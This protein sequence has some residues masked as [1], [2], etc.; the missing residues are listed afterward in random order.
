[1]KKSR[2]AGLFVLVGAGLTVNCSSG[3]SGESVSSLQAADS[4]GPEAD[5]AGDHDRDDRDRDHDHHEDASCSISKEG[6]SAYNLA[7]TETHKVD[8]GRL[9]ITRTFKV[10]E[11]TGDW[12]ATS[13]LALNDHPILAS[14]IDTKVDHSFHATFDYGRPVSGPRHVDVTSTDGQTATAVVDGKPTLA[15]PVS[16]SG[17]P[18]RVRFENGKPVPANEISDGE[19]DE[20]VRRLAG[21]AAR[22]FEPCLKDKVAAAAA[23]F[24]VPSSIV[25]LALRPAAAA[26]SLTQTPVGPIQG[27]N[28]GLCASAQ[29]GVGLAWGGCI[30]GGAAA[31]T[32]C[33][34]L[35]W[36]CVAV[37][38]V[39]CTAGAIG[40][41]AAV[42]NTSVCCPV[43]CDPGAFDPFCCSEHDQCFDVGFPQC[44]ANGSACG[45]ECCAP[46][47]KCV[48][49]TCCEPGA[50]CGNTCCDNG[51]GLG[52]VCVDAATSTCC[53]P[54]NE[55]CSV[56]ACC[57][58]NEICTPGPDLRGL[59]VPVPPTPPTCRPGLLSCKVNEDCPVVNQFVP[60]CIEGCCIDTPN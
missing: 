15:F 39:G 33:G 51:N 32:G 54:P 12:L 31:S 22:E 49:G 3:G 11:T 25:A 56:S 42:A 14:T 41:S 58:P 46:N 6:P 4:R 28:N 20:E 37:T 10:D 48:G 7:F 59:C 44:C 35:A 40:T 55:R 9:S 2:L 45:S 26:T 24:G 5:K 57:N 53:M 36:L 8:G 52:G 38:V 17:A 23:A 30:A 19:L 21:D 43:N 13:R 1:M 18:P 27:I 50:E 34:P 29:L 47:V 16:K 60:A